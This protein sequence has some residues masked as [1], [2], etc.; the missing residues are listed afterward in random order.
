MRFLG[1]L[2]LLVLMPGA[3][4]AGSDAEFL[5]ARDA[6]RAGQATKLAAYVPRFKGHVLEPYPAYWRVNLRL[7]QASAADVRAFLAAYPDTPLAEKLRADWA[8]L[9]ARTRQ[10][11]LFDEE[12]P[13]V[14]NPGLDL[15]CQS[16]QSR[17]RA[18]PDDALREARPLWF[19]GRD[20][21]ESCTPLFNALVAGGQLSGEDLWTRI[22]LALEAGQ[23]GVARRIAAYLPADQSPAPKV[24]EAIFA[25]PAGHLEQK[26]LAPRGRA[27]R[28][29]TLFAVHRLARTSPQQAARHWT[30]LEEGFP[31][32]DRAY[33]WA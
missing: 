27:E 18:N 2:A 32:E 1:F 29:A 4:A 3:H 20:L 12:F 28:E 9:L 5:A 7:E 33:V 13:R 30:R 26:N 19:V 31:A 21:P 15:T 23:V 10:W 14:H 24:L 17:M 6:Y 16:L 8:K 22:R 11:E 25:N